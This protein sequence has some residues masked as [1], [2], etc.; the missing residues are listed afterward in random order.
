MTDT[1]VVV[2]KSSLP[3][4]QVSAPVP[5]AQA[6]VDDDFAPMWGIHAH[7]LFASANEALDPAWWP[8]YVYDRTDTPGAGGYHTDDQGRVS[9]KVFALDAIE[10]GEAWTVDLTHELLEMLGD[11]TA[12]TDPSAMINL[13]GQYAG[14]QCLP[15]AC[16]AVE[17][18]GLAYSKGT[19][20]SVVRVM[21]SDFVLPQYF[22]RPPVTS[23]AWPTGAPMAY[24][25]IGHLTSGPAPTLLYGGYLGIFDPRTASWSQVS[26]FDKAG[27]HS[28]RS[29]RHGRTA[30]RA[31]KPL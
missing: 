27:R 29:Q 31:S 2:N 13:T 17:A 15:E 7:I 30:W 5:A 3:D 12:G 14:L 10:G 22:F 4:S 19:P 24:D 23:P 8:L 11:P 1:I 16:D 20:G 9:G 6:Q 21:V 18:D 26:M 28:R 25:F